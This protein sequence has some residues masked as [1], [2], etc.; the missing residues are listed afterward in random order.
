MEGI[1]ILT[2]S[3]F[4]C[5]PSTLGL[6]VCCLSLTLDRRWGAAATIY[7]QFSISDSVVFLHHKNDRFHPRMS[8]WGGDFKNVKLFYSD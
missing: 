3:T 5:A 8:P 4:A 1:D 2:E 7:I 6:R